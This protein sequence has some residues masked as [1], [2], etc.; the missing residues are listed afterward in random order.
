M[1]KIYIFFFKKKERKY[2]PRLVAVIMPH[3]FDR[4]NLD[5]EKLLEKTIMVWI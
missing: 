1:T 5:D 3:A 4:E 2:K